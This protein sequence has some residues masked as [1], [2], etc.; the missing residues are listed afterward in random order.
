MAIARLLFLSVFLVN[1]LLIAE[2]KFEGLHEFARLQI[3]NMDWQFSISGTP[4]QLGSK[5]QLIH[6]QCNDLDDALIV[7]QRMMVERIC[8]S[9]LPSYPPFYRSRVS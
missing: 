7:G 5:L 8:S 4:N 6:H 3:A 2:A 9:A 1:L